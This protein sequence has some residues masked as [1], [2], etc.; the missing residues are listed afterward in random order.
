MCT[1]SL[2]NTDNLVIFNQDPNGGV[3]YMDRV[4]LREIPTLE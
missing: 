4:E 3:F 1:N 2:A